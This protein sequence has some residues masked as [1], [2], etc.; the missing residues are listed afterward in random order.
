MTT[1]A[2]IRKNAF[3]L[4][5]FVLALVFL[6]LNGV[7]PPWAKVVLVLLASFGAV[8]QEQGGQMSTGRARLRYLRDSALL[9]GIILAFV[10][11]P[12]IGTWI[13][14]GVACALL[15]SL[16]G[17]PFRRQPPSAAASDQNRAS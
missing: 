16:L 13:G 9:S 15:L 8:A 6:F 2:E 11:S 5:L 7:L 12:G 17:S 10:L 3:V 1:L 4:P 14:F